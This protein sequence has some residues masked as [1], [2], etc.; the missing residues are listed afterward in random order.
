MEVLLLQNLVFQELRK[1][2]DLVAAVEVTLEPEEQELQALHDKVM[3]VAQ[4]H[5][6]VMVVEVA[7]VRQ[8]EMEILQTESH[9]HGQV[10][11]A[12]QMTSQERAH[13]TAGVAALQ[14]IR[15][16]V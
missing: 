10:E 13:I 7:L 4:P 5:N 8:A 3:T 14:V 12:L 16:V 1:T 11:L 2:V 9:L 6:P 15:E